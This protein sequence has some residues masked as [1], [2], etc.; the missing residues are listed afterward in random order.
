MKKMWLYIL[1]TFVVLANYSVA[2]GDEIVSED[3][4]TTLSLEEAVEEA[5]KRSQELVINELDI[6]VKKTEISEA[7]FKE[8]KYKRSDF[9][10]GTVEGFALDESMLSTQAKYAYEEEKLKTKY[11]KENIKY[12]VTNAY[13]GVLQTREY[14]KVTESTLENIKKNND[15]VNK[16]FELGMASKSDVLMSDIGLNEGYVNIEKA[17]EDVEKASRALNMLLNYPLDSK[18]ELTS[19]FEEQKFERNIEEDLETAYKERFDVIQL[20][21]NYNLLKLD[22][23]VTKK[24]YTPNTF[25]YKYK[26][27]SLAKV[28]NLLA[29]SKRNIEF[30]IRSKYDE[31]KSAEKQIQLAKTNIKK[32]EEGL[33]LRELA[34]NAGTGI[35]LEVKESI[36]QLYNTRLALSNAIANYNLK[37]LEYNKAVNI[38]V[39]R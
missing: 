36:T 2:Y 16:R 38:G 34:Y 19:S 25:V 39:V 11:I 35:M 23:D 29:D 37:I 31:I 1:L 33:R 10:L 27:S 9:S 21:N 28:E 14:L 26:N 6:D 24:V 7:N 30:D 32:A 13:Y 12:N 8:R 18:L 5:I 22:F 20:D 4:K 15:M 3:I 17:R